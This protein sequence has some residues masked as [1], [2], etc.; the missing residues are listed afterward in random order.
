MRFFT[1][2]NDREFVHNPE[3][4]E[5]LHLR[6]SAYHESGHAAVALYIGCLVR[7]AYIYDER[8]RYAGDTKFDIPRSEAKEKADRDS[9]EIQGIS[10]STRLEAKRQ[11]RRDDSLLSFVEVA[12][13]MTDSM[14]PHSRAL[15]PPR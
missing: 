14:P 7:E 5:D 9:G 13:A 2:T 4:K 3:D 1:G 8:G 12:A 6:H 10:G 15:A 11:R